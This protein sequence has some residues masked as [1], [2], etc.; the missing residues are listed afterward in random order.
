MNT[1]VQKATKADK[2]TV[3]LNANHATKLAEFARLTHIEREDLV[4]TMLE[5]QLDCYLDT[6]MGCVEDLLDGRTYA[7]AEE[8]RAIADAINERNTA[9]GNDR[10]PLRTNGRK[11]VKPTDA[12][13]ESEFNRKH[14]APEANQAARCNSDNYRVLNTLPVTGDAYLV[15]LNPR[16]AKDLQQLAADT[17][18]TPEKALSVAALAILSC[19]T[20]GECFRELLA[21][22]EAPLIRV[23]E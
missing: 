6:G 1:K 17:N 9:A 18:I 14:A 20:A 5:Q 4:N 12:E 21:E 15:K 8:A 2:I 22:T 16:A 3:E 13:Q 11:I 10:L 19:S 7:T 23:V